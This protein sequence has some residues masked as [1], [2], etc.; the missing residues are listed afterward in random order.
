MKQIKNITAAEILKQIKLTVICGEEITK[1]N[2]CDGFSTWFTQFDASN[3]YE[4]FT[5]E[6]RE[7]FQNKL[8]VA[9]AAGMLPAEV[10]E[11]RTNE[12]GPDGCWVFTVETAGTLNPYEETETAAPTEEQ[13]TETE[14]EEEETETPATP[15]EMLKVRDVIMGRGGYRERELF[16]APHT[17]THGET[18]NDAHKVVNILATTPDPDGYRPGCAVDIVAR[19]IVG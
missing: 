6:S 15:G 5:P 19:A 1:T 18:W 2:V 3:P 12:V 13:T 10:T 8:F 17:M 4:A 7:Y 9:F 11:T 14:T 16:K